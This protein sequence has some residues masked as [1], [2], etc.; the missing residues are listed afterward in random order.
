MVIGRT[1]GVGLRMG[2]EGMGK[3]EELWV[4]KRGGL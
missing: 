3:G 1:I 4:G 2:N